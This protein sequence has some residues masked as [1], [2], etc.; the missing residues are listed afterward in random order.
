MTTVTGSGE[1]TLMVGTTIIELSGISAASP[2]IPRS[3][4]PIRVTTSMNAN[5]SG[6]FPIL[7]P[8]ANAISWT[9]NVASV[10]IKPNWR[11]L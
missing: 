11:Y 6:D 5:M 2:L 10:E 8:G 7:K 3:W 9:G 1:I 4:R